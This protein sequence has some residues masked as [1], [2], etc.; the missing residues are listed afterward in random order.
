VS[1]VKASRPKPTSAALP[2]L[3]PE[4]RAATASK[5]FPGEGEVFEPPASL[6][7]MTPFCG[8]LL[9]RGLPS[10]RNAFVGVVQRLAARKVGCLERRDVEPCGPD[11]LINFPVEMASSTDPLP[12]GVLT[13]LAM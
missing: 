3:K 11:E 2:E 1:L 9:L 13:G 5:R 12:V 6:E 10:L 7:G 4:I 8:D